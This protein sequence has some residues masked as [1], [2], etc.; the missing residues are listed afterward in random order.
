M[1]SELF[2]HQ[3]GAFTGADAPRSG[4][5]ELAD[6]GTILL[7]EV[8][9]IDLNLQAKLLRVLQEKSFERVGSSETIRVD[10]RVLATTNRDL[11]S[12]VADGR[13]RQDLYYRLAVVPLWVPPLRQRSEDVAELVRYFLNRSAA[14]LGRQPVALE[15]SAMELLEGY[16]WPGNVRELENIITRVSVLGSASPLTAHELRRW[17]EDATRAD[18]ATPPEGTSPDVPLGL[19][20]E[21]MERRLIEA[22]LEQF[23]GHR[24]K[25]AKALGIGVRTLSGKL[26]QY[27][28]APRTKLFSR[29]G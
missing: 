4:R 5:F 15:R 7:D 8:S 28:Y 23:G 20:L 3:R 22:T 25:T 6:G 19:S 29:A 26:R 13:F 14:R 10:V 16:H 11:E 9:E 12:E 27:G 21:E 17:L 2:G 24:E 1:E 18:R